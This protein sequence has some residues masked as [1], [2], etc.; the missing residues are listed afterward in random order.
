MKADYV[1]IDGVAYSTKH[2]KALAL[3]CSNEPNLGSIPNQPTM[4][5][6][7]NSGVA[8]HLT[9]IANWIQGGQLPESHVAIKGKFPKPLS[10]KTESRF[11]AI[12]QSRQYN[13]IWEQAITL[14]LDAPFKSYRPDYAVLRNGVVMLFEVKARHRF[15][16]AGIAK[17]ALAAKT[18]PQF[19]FVLAM[20]ED[21]KF[22]ETVL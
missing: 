4:V 1:M 7:K 8:K 6:Q 21:G 13:P 20:W 16:R 5:P 18:Y 2:P 10:N 11:K 19:Q 12:L 9:P 14:K 22:T 3:Q 17:A 15:A